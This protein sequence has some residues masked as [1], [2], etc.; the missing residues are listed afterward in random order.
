MA[1]TGGGGAVCFA[2][3]GPGTDP[4]GRWCPG[5]VRPCGAGRQPGPWRCRRS[6]WPGTCAVLRCMTVFRRVARQAIGARREARLCSTD[7][8][9]TPV[10]PAG[11]AGQGREVDRNRS[12]CRQL[13]ATNS[14]TGPS[15]QV[16]SAGEARNATLRSRS[17]VTDC[18]SEGI[19]PRYNTQS[20]VRQ[21]E[22][23]GRV[24][25]VPWQTV[26]VPASGGR[27]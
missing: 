16:Q 5:A 7:C 4:R 8:L 18:L 2:P 22:G 14:P 27:R 26:P 19:F 3:S 1:R 25:Q 11:S 15:C 24:Q 21:L 13:R 9:T 6:R 23:A 17:T 12:L 10:R 20:H